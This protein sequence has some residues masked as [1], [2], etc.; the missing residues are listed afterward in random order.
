M[1]DNK[2]EVQKTAIDLMPNIFHECLEKGDPQITVGHLEEILDNLFKVLDDPKCARNHAAAKD[3]ISK[4]VNDV[5]AMKDPGMYTMQFIVFSLR[6]YNK[7]KPKRIGVVSGGIIV[8]EV[9]FSKCYLCT[10]TCFCIGANSENNV[11]RRCTNSI[12]I[13]AR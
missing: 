6:M 5:I 4:V 11:W 2:P 1:L 7:T 13:W 12:Q 10:S 3:A 8:R 9:R